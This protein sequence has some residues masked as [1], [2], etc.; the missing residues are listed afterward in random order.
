[1]DPNLHDE[2]PPVLRDRLAA[3]RVASTAIAPPARLE[4]ALRA[5]LASAPH[6]VALANA[7]PDPA[8]RAHASSWT[9]RWANWIAWPVSV[10][11]AA[12]LLSWMVYSNPPIAPESMVGEGAA[13]SVEDSRVATPFL[14]LAPFGDIDPVMRGEVVR[15]TV[16]RA[17]LAEFGLPVSPMRAAEPIDADFL[18]GSDGGILAVRFVDA[19]GL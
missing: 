19:A 3:L 17:T 12:G 10:T 18:V 13:N 1:M 6:G 16:P 2:C 4:D 9:A 15:T 11:A 14:A 8:W 7:R 5:R